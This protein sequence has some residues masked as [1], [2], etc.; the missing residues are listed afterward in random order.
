MG[1]YADDEPVPLADAL[2][3]VG[4]ELGLPPGNVHGTLEAR[5]GEVMGADVAPHARLVSVRDG[6]LTYI[7]DAGQPLAVTQLALLATNIRNIRSPN[8]TFPSPLHLDAKVL[9]GG[10][11]RLDG[12]ANFLAE[13]Q[14][15]VRA[16][17]ELKGIP[18]K[19]L[20]PVAQDANLHISGGTLSALGQVESTDKHRSARLAR[21]EIDNIAVDY[22]HSAPTA[23]AEAR[24][25]ALVSDTAADIA[26][27]PDMTVDIDQL[28]IKNGSLGYVDQSAKP[29]FRVFLDKS[30]IEV[31]DIS[32]RPNAP[33]GRVMASGQL[34]GAGPSSAWI[35]F[36]PRQHDPVLDLAVQIE[37][38]PLKSLNDVLQAE[39]NFDVTAGEFAFYSELHVADGAINGYVKPLFTDIDVYNRAQDKHD[40]L[41]HQV[42]EGMVGGLATLLENRS[43]AVAT[44]ATVRGSTESPT[45]STWQVFL[46]LVRNA[47]FKAILPGFNHARGEDSAPPAP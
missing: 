28:R 36:M 47:F 23:A 12:A 35:S 7:D 20:A 6:T 37:K 38:T 5:W 1:R 27:Q 26:K 30:Q 4:A 9:E 39:G 34:M 14:P 31:R 44:Q 2:A 42:Y 11:L 43:D 45:L 13:P 22:V 8:D 15:N 25:A 17:I 33:R 18:L 41:L 29:P 32:T 19:R 46:N 40:P 24:R 10:S 21:A 16:E 3:K